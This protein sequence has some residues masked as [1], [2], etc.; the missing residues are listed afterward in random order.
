MSQQ[1]L[2]P[3]SYPKETHTEALGNGPGCPPPHGLIG[4]NQKQAG[5]ST[6][7]G[8]GWWLNTSLMWKVVQGKG[9][10]TSKLE[11]HN[12]RVIPLCGSMCLLMRAPKSGGWMNGLRKPQPLHGSGSQSACS[13]S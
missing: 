6:A 10:E 8:V 13:A 12:F 9:I 2:S 3:S 1:S 7:R 5:L 11:N 4:E